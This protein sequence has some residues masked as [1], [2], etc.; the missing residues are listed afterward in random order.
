MS[1]G[2][3]IERKFSRYPLP[4]FAGRGERGDRIHAGEELA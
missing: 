2:C 1:L 3:L 4:Q